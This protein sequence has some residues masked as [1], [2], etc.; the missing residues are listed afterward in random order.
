MVTHY[1]TLN[2]FCMGDIIP[3]LASENQSL[4]RPVGGNTVITIICPWLSVLMSPSWRKGQVYIL[5]PDSQ[6][7]LLA[8]PLSNWGISS[9]LFHFPI[10]E[11]P[12]LFSGH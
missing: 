6:V 1:V 5:K 9:W 11:F 12:H 10:L 3:S 7:H 8:L 2:D 4:D